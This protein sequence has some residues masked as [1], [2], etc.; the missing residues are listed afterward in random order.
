MAERP[1]GPPSPPPLHSRL[2]HRPHLRHR[3]VAAAATT[4]DKRGVVRYYRHDSVVTGWQIK[5]ESPGRLKLKNPVLYRKNDLCQAIER[6]LM[7]VL[8][9]DKYR[10]ELDRSARSRSI[11]TRA[12]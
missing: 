11:T 10:D 4:R 3:T 7:S 6:E 5:S 2:P 9:I 8:G 1:V 12:S